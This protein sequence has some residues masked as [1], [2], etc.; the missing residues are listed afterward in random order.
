MLCHVVMLKY[1]GKK[2]CYPDSPT[3]NNK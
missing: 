2:R 1:L 3:F